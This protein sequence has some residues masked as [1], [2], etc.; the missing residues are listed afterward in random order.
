MNALESLKDQTDS[1]SNIMPEFLNK[2]RAFDWG[3]QTVINQYKNLNQN[4]F[5]KFW[6]SL[7]QYLHQ[8]QNQNRKTEHTETKTET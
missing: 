4:Q 5:S 8:N 7:N 2:H 1:V 6:F 3:S